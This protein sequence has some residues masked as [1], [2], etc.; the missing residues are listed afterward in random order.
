MTAS[1]SLVM[2]YHS[3][4]ECG[5]RTSIVWLATFTFEGARGMYRGE[6]T[7]G[8]DGMTDAL[9]ALR[10]KNSRWWYLGSRFTSEQVVSGRN[11]AL[12]VILHRFG[13]MALA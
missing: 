9:P 7:V 10:R 13:E 2:R 5:E 11:A 12:R 6:L 4:E 1:S 3:S 8:G